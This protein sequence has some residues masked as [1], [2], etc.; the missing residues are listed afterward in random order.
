MFRE[1]DRAIIS[2]KANL[3]Y[4]F[5]F[6]IFALLIAKAWYLQV[7]TGTDFYSRSQENSIRMIEQIPSRGLIFDHAG[8]IIVDNRPAFSL[9]VLPAEIP[10]SS[11]KKI[12]DIAKLNIGEVRE[13]IH[14]ANHYRPL[15]I[16]RQIS[17]SLRIFIEENL[18]FFPGITIQTEPKRFY[19][20]P[21]IIPHAL[22]YIGEVNEK[23][24]KKSTEYEA[25]DIVGKSG[26]EEVYD[27]QLR[28]KRG[29][30]YIRVDVHGRE[31][32]EIRSKYI[33]PVAAKNL[34]LTTD[35]KLQEYADN[36]LNKYRGAL[37]AID[38]R[39]GAIIAM[40]SKPDYAPDLLSGVVT[41]NEWSKLIN[42][43]DKPLTSRGY[44]GIYPP[45]SVFKL[46]SS[47]MATD[48]NLVSPDWKV[49]CN[50]SFKIGRKTMLCWNHKGHG[51]VSML[52]AI[53]GSCNVYFYNLSLKMDL[54][55]WA[56][57]SRRFGFGRKT[58]IDVT[59]ENS[60][61]VPSMNYYD[62]K[63]GKGGFTRGHLANLVI[64]QGEILA[65]PLQLAQYAM[66]LANSGEY[67]QPHLID[68]MVDVESGDTL[69]YKPVK[70]IVSI[71]RSSFDLSRR[72]M[73]AVVLGGT[74]SNV[75]L[76][77][78][79]IAGKTGTAQNPHGAAHSWF[80]GFAPFENPEIVI[81]VLV[82]NGGSGSYT[83]A[84]I[85]R[86]FFEMYF[87]GKV[88]MDHRLYK[89]K[90]KDELD[91]LK[92]LLRIEPLIKVNDD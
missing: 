46:V 56:D 87:Y 43:P 65:S 79:D 92:E 31:I 84:P 18:S 30:R 88:S 77:D 61:L 27:L 69:K 36:E 41:P 44:Q 22:G 51:E 62:R 50:G 33:S 58:G 12:C 48:I 19:P 82:E 78:V 86:R 3:F 14:R 67:Y 49:E 81:A 54:K 63:I 76:V 2:V 75:A 10:D 55:T 28:G 11:L 83:A 13:K 66:I 90:A 91:E 40:S 57:Y 8:N 20:R 25:G 23:S 85:A 35:R 32:G 80:I 37:V 34:Y 64:G 15:T 89:P 42:D 21:T 7:E 38:P 72:G 39:N 16:K 59:G 52:D 68:Y 4:F 5:S 26:L 17:E 71:P 73:K 60:G 45:G 9:S 29:Y 1:Q 6:A 70:K 47:V 74:A 53:R 24:M